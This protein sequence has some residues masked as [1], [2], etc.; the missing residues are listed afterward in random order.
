[1]RRDRVEAEITVQSHDLERAQPLRIH[2][3]EWRLRSW[4]TR[5]RLDQDQC[6]PVG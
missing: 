3:H 6:V 5:P 1:M 2:D 4:E